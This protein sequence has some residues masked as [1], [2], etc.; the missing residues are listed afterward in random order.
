MLVDIAL[1]IFAYVLGTGLAI[2]GFF[3]ALLKVI[4]HPITRQSA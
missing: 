1:A 3:W 4:G 2:A